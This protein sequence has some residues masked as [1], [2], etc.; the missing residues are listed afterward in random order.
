MLCLL[1]G[2]CNK[3]QVDLAEIFRGDP[4]WFKLE[5]IS[6]PIVFHG[7]QHFELRCGIC[8]FPRNFDILQKLRNDR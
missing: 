1:V 7:L 3:L 5:V 4:S 2:L 6:R 8:P